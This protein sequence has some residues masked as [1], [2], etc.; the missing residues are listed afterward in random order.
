M[1]SSQV[2]ELVQRFDRNTFREGLSDRL[3]EI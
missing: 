1:T 3:L 2:I